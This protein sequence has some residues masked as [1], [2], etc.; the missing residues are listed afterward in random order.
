MVV[1]DILNDKCHSVCIEIRSVQYITRG[2]II[3][4][5]SECMRLFWINNQT[6]FLIF[7]VIK[8]LIFQAHLD[9][10]AI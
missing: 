9:Y 6:E 5:I 1:T 3:C 7:D 2:L 8:M 10:K 4:Y